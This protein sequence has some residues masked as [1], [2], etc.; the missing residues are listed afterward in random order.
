MNKWVNMKPNVEHNVNPYFH[1]FPGPRVTGHKQSTR[2]SVAGRSVTSK[3]SQNEISK[4]VFNVLL[5]ISL[6]LIGAVIIMRQLLYIHL[7]RNPVKL[8]LAFWVS[9]RYKSYTNLYCSRNLVPLT[10]FFL[11]F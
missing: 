4:H 10:T 3:V 11:G 5:S 6:K 2:R 8:Q 1:V 9:Q 7:G